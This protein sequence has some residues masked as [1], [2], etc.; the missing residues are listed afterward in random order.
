MD[1]QKPNRIKKTLGIL[2]A[3]CFLM[4]VTAIAVSASSSPSSSKA[5]GVKS[6]TSPQQNEPNQFVLQGVAPK[7]GNVSIIYSTTSLASKPILSYTDSKGT[8]KN[9]TGDQIRTQETEIGT[10]VTV[11]SLMTIDFGGKKLTI[12]IPAIRLGDSAQKFKT[13]AVV[14]TYYGPIIPPT[15]RVLQ[16]YEVID[17]KGTASRVTP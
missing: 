2:L 4:S 11:T 7:Y 15:T 1:K 9:F 13:I 6:I 14:T 16:T 3:V 8:H 10:M 5:T 12:L 17:L